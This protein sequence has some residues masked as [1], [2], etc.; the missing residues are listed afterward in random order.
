LANISP[1]VQIVCIDKYDCPNWNLPDTVSKVIV[2]NFKTSKTSIDIP[3]TINQV[4]VINYK[5]SKDVKI[6]VPANCTI[7]NKYGDKI[8]V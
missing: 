5:I 3:N 1:S 8:N 2:K 6:N 4:Q 7:V